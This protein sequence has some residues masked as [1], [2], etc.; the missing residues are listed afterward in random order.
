MQ[1]FLIVTM[2]ARDDQGIGFGSDFKRGKHLLDRADKYA[3]GSRKSLV[4]GILVSV[5]DDPDVLLGIVRADL[6]VVRAAPTGEKMVPLRLVFQQVAVAIYD[7][8][9]VLE[10]GRS[11]RR[12]LAE[13]SIASRVSFGCLWW[14]R[15]FA[16]L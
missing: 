4:I 2:S 5:V 11:L 1:G 16:A 12:G 6:D 7:Q 10:P 14:D 9:A 8:Y 15:E 3:F 13:R